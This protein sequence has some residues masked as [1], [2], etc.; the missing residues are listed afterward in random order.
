MVLERQFDPPLTTRDVTELAKASTWCFEQYDTRWLGSL[1]SADGRSMVCRFEAA[2]AE[3]IRQVLRT[4]E[5]DMRIL[6]PATVHEVPEPGKANV[7]VER[8]FDEPC[9]LD[10]LQA[11][12][13]SRQWCLDTHNVK[14]VRTLLSHDRKRMLCLYSGP[15]AEAVRAAQRESGMPMDRVW[16]FVDVG[17]A[18]LAN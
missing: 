3:T 15:D 14:F 13:D 4:V 10:E 11:Q 18:D 7:I 1:L 9:V 16:S 5:A 8:S 6:W 17:M 2:D 12:E